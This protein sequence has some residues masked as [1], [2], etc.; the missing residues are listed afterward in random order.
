MTGA[1]ACAAAA[2]VCGAGGAVR[3]K[4]SPLGAAGSSAVAVLARPSAHGGMHPIV[5]IHTLL[6]LKLW[7]AHTVPHFVVVP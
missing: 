1:A 3:L 2:A 6:E 7:P 4:V 5:T